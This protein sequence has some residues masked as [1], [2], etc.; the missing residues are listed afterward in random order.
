MSN[1]IWLLSLFA[2][3]AQQSS[4]I[5]SGNLQ[6]KVRLGASTRH[7]LMSNADLDKYFCLSHKD[8]KE[9]GFLHVRD[10]VASEWRHTQVLGGANNGGNNNTEKPCLFS[11]SP[12]IYELVDSL[13]ISLCCSCSDV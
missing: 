8:Y 11:M 4:G 12:Y 6:V 3:N 5:F 7:M 1:L 10:Y 13:T 9:L 2:A